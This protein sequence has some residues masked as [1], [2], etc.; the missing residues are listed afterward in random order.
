MLAAVNAGAER[1]KQILAALNRDGSFKKHVKN[2]SDSLEKKLQHGAARRDKRKNLKDFEIKPDYVEP[3]PFARGGQAV[4][5]LGEYAA[6]TV[7]IKC[8]NMVGV[9]AEINQ[10]VRPAWRYYLL[11]W[12]PRRSTRVLGV[13]ARGVLGLF[14]RTFVFR[15][16]WRARCGAHEDVLLLCDGTE[17][18][19]QIKTPSDRASAG[20][21]HDRRHVP[22]LSDGVHARGFLETGAQ[23]GG[24]GDN[25]GVPACVEFNRCIGC[26]IIIH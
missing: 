17:H 26:P 16:G 21:H 22:R 15:T 11:F 2:I 10:C 9:S 7:C 23:Q 12:Q 19:G 3:D 25:S 20:N 18:Y 5:K 1:D 13:L 6:E 8:I 14:T 24:R 4:V